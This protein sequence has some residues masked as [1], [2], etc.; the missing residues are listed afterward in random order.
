MVKRDVIHKF[1]LRKIWKEAIVYL[2]IGKKLLVYCLWLERKF[3]GVTRNDITIMVI[4]GQIEM[5]ATT[6]MMT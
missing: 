3:Y 6:L 5:A 1:W 4:S 2:H